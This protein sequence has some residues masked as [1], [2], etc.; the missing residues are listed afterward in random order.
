MRLIDLDADAGAGMGLFEDIHHTKDEAGHDSA[1]A[2]AVRL[3][4]AACRYYGTAARQFVQLLCK[5]DA[6]S[7]IDVIRDL[8][9]DFLAQCNLGDV[10]PEVGRAVASLSILAAAGELAST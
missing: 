3:K 7:R 2:F 9:S 1:K 4:D 6:E 8:Q 5:L 10:G